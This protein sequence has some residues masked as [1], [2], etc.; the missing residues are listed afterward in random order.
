LA[1]SCRRADPE[2]TEEV[3][4]RAAKIVEADPV[5]IACSS[6]FSSAMASS[7]SS[8]ERPQRTSTEFERALSPKLARS[9]TPR[10]F[11][12]QSGGGDGSGGVSAT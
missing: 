12:S 11:R 2:A 1:S 10:R 9:P 5:S 4:G 8:S 7:P 3:I 6:T